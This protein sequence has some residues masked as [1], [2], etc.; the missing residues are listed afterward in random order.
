[1][2]NLPKEIED[3]LKQPT[4]YEP[5]EY[6][7]LMTM[8]DGFICTRD[9]AIIVS[10]DGKEVNRSRT[11]MNLIA[12]KIYELSDQ[13]VAMFTGSV[14]GSINDRMDMQHQHFKELGVKNVT[15]IANRITNSIS[16]SDARANGKLEQASVIV[17]GYDCINAVYLPH[18]YII[19][20]DKYGKWDKH[21]TGVH[22]LHAGEA[23]D[24]VADVLSNEFD[25]EANLETMN[26][27]AIKTIRVASD[28]KPKSTGGQTQLWNLRPHRPIK[29]FTLEEIRLI[30]RNP[31]PDK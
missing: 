22:C 24:A 21:E 30:E 8:I 15:D 2:Y 5:E 13:C 26:R 23:F 12:E 7:D 11:D 10:A 19:Y 27:L 14:P 25:A 4:Y 31:P 28:D 17:A 1:M 3:A 20:K 18:L 16:R 29:K 6:F 9:P